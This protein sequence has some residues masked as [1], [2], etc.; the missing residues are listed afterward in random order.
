MLKWNDT[1]HITFL[2]KDGQTLK[3]ATDVYCDQLVS[4]LDYIEEGVP[5]NIIAGID[6]G[7]NGGID[8]INL[9]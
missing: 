9:N 4:V 6:F 2:D 8:I 7:Q 3:T 1:Y 5:N